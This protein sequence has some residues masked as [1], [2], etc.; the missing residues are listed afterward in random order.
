LKNPLKT[1]SGKKKTLPP[2]CYHFQLRLIPPPNNV[3]TRYLLGFILNYT[4]LPK[5]NIFNG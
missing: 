2:F 1:W 4:N 3:G 5:G